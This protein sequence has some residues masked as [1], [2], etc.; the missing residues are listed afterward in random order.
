MRRTLALALVCAT[1]LASTLH[2]QAARPGLGARATMPGGGPPPGGGGGGAEF[3][4]AHTGDLQLTDAQVVR[5]AAIARRSAERRRAMRATMDSLRAANRP[6]MRDSAAR[7]RRPAGPPPAA[8][9]ALE[10]ARDAAH[11]DL[12]DAIAVLTADQQARAWEMRSGP[13]GGPGGGGGR[14][15]FGPR[16]GRGDDGPIGRRDRDEDG[17]L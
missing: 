13:R 10:R 11:A 8:V 15:G 5:L 7:G 9:A 2:A 3:L 4:L 16:R 6:A 1:S 12:R 14:P 17:E